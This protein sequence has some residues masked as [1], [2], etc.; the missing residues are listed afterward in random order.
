VWTL[1]LLA[2][3]GMV[4]VTSWLI[5]WKLGA[6]TVTGFVLSAYLVGFTEIVALTLALSVIRNLRWWT[7]LVG[8]GV[9]LVAALALT[10]RTHPSTS[11]VT[12]LEAFREGLREPIVAVLALGVALGLGYS[13]A[14]GLLTPPN[15]WDAMSYHLAR[16]AL[17]IQ[18]GGVGYVDNSPFAPINAYPPNAEIGTLF[19]L[20]L[21]H[22]DRY[23]G[24]VQYSAMLATATATFGI[25]RRAGIERNAALFG[26][27]AFLTLP[28]VLLQSWTAL[29]DLA[30]AS[31]L[32]T[33]T[34]F[35]LGATRLELVLGGLSLALAT[36]TKFTAFIA[37]PLVV[38]VALAGQPRFRWPKV[39]LALV[40]GSAVGGYWLIVN[41]VNTGSIDAGA[42]D[43]LEQSPDRSPQAVLARTSRL[44]VHF[45][46]SLALERDVVLFLIGGILLIV[47]ALASDRPPARRWPFVAL[48]IALVAFVP[49][50]M[51][52]LGDLLL[53]AHEKVWL[54]VGSRDLAFLDDNRDQHSPSTVFSYYGSLG[55]VLITAGIVL[56][57]MAVRR[58]A[59]P[60][61]TLAL[62]TAPVLFALALSIA[63]S[64]DPF[65]GRFFLFSVALAASTWGLALPHR[66]LAW[67]ATAVAV[68][69]VPLSFVHSTEKP[70]DHSIFDRGES[71]SVWGKSRETVQTW[72][73]QDGTS[74]V[75]DFFAREPRSGR[76]GLRVRADD[77]IYP[78]FGRTL[79]RKVVFVR[80]GTTEPSLDWL[81]LA[82]GREGKP[83]PRWSLALKTDD[84]WRVYRPVDSESRS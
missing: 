60:P 78:Y 55:F 51:R 21:S 50:A 8:A 35:L 23:V 56:G 46:D 30:V 15:D 26:A 53:R 63:I 65:R 20:I 75:V 22:G 71:S 34:Y 49:V 18:Q 47:V 38:L 76:V 64:Y 82:P 17:W 41:L 81:V 77:W 40:A 19:T 73:R 57:A 2:G 7:V 62:A 10:R 80:N 28:L 27:L 66:W 61:V 74:E 25:G 9:V 84:G 14:L 33:A 58:R 52:T 79:D 48:G 72:L 36:G 24:L 68:V 44:L 32:I 3:L 13:A 37:L 6:P 69:T 4:A 83:G 1:A 16:A 43:A 11:V 54:T 5:A 45:A 59:A 42:S 70:L 12:G 29:N 67:G 39:A 31:F